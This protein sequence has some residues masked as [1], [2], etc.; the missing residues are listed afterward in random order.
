M[1]PSLIVVSFAHEHH[2]LL[3]GL[4]FLCGS[5]QFTQAYL[6]ESVCTGTLS[7]IFGLLRVGSDGYVAY[8]YM[9]TQDIGRNI[10]LS[11]RHTLP[12]PTRP[13]TPV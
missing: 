4:C 2:F 11:P 5:R 10:P 6:D 7:H 9:H 12:Q 8:L 13:T 1:Q 3:M